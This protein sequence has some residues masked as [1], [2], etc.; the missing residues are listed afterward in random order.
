MVAEALTKPDPWNGI[1]LARSQNAEPRPAPR[2]RQNPQ[3]LNPLRID[4]DPLECCPQCRQLQVSVESGLEVLKA[5]AA[6]TPKMTAGRIG[7]AR[8][9]I[10]PLDNPALTPA[11]AARAE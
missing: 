10:E 6:A 3:R 9:R 7:A 8:P 1:W 2:W 11:A 4:P 5:A